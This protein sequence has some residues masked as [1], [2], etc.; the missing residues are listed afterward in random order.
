M[1]TR[2]PYPSDL[3]DAWW[4]LIDPEA[5]PTCSDGTGRAPLARRPYDLRHAC[6]TRWLNAGVP[7]AE[8]ARRVGDSQ[9]VIHRRHHGCIDGHEE[10]ANAKITKDLEEEGDTA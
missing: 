8:V 9:E 5:L 4:E 2:H 6:I 7:I 1:S 3:S 10:A